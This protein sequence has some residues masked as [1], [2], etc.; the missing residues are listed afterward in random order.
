MSEPESEPKSRPKSEP[1]PQAA[2]PIVEALHAIAS[3]SQARFYLPGHKG[4]QG[5]PDILREAL[6]ETVW[7][8]DLPELPDFD[9]LAIP[10]GAIA[11]AQTLAARAFGAD[12]TWFLCN[13]STAGVIAALSATC[14]PGDRVLMPRNVHRSAISGLV[15]CGAVPVFAAPSIA[16]PDIDPDW[17]IDRGLQPEAVARALDRHPELAA[18]FL[19]SPNYYGLSCDLPAIVRLARAAEV[20]RNSPLPVIVDAA[21]G[22]HFPF[23]SDLPAAALAAGADVAIESTHKTLGALSQASM[24]HL[25]GDRVDA[26]RLDRAL[27]LVQSTS[28]NALLLASLDAARHQMATAGRDWLDR[29]LHCADRLRAG[30]IACGWPVWHPSATAKIASSVASSDERF[31]RTRITLRTQDFG[32][33]GYSADDWLYERGVAAELPTDRHLTF[34]VTLGNTDADVD[35]ALEALRGLKALRSTGD[36]APDLAIDL[37]TAAWPELSEPELSPRDAFFA[38]TETIV[39]AQSRD[40]ICAD[41]LCPYPPGI[42]L[43]FPGERI[44]A[45]SIAALENIAGSGGTITGWPGAG[46]VRV[47][48]RARMAGGS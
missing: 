32:L 48:R 6:G 14:R 33:S 45:Q 18:I 34:V 46:Q 9:T 40:R 11:E 26:D 35:R 10:T 21:H 27:S 17:N 31:D 13:G 19:V 47:V 7:R 37:D 28:P 43:L 2:Q 24:L 16:A 44:T 5:A 12:R 36:R 42:P 4:G 22:S 23:H 20:H 38:E 39:L 8:W 25:K 30:A 15:Q 1:S 3:R 41:T 29:T